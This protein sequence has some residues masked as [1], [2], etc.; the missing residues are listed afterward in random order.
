M[1]DLIVDVRCYTKSG[2]KFGSSHIRFLGRRQH[3]GSR[4][5]L[6]LSDQRRHSNL[7]RNG[8]FLPLTAPI[9]IR[10]RRPREEGPP[11]LVNCPG[12]DQTGLSQRL[13]GKKTP[14]LLIISSY[15]ALR[16]RAKPRPARPTPN[17]ASVP[18]SGISSM[19]TSSYPR[20]S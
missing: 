6:P 19:T 12:G 20:P 14:S 13:G 5:K 17:R 8:P 16:R 10:R 7:Y 2:R 1:G 9:T 18:G 4:R 15:A 11:L 3:R